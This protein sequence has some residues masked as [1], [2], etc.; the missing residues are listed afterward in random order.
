MP[1][2]KDTDEGMSKTAARIVAFEP[3]GSIRW[4]H[5]NG[6]QLGVTWSYDTD[7]LPGGNLFLTAT[8]RE[9]GE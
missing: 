3:N 8:Y 1:G 7:P 6:K 5:R 4:V 2:A 9:D